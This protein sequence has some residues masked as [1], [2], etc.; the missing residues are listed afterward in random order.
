MKH[1]IALLTVLQTAPMALAAECPTR[2]TL[3]TGIRFTLAS[4]ETETFRT[5]AEG[6]VESLFEGPEQPANRVLLGRGVYLLELIGVDSGIPDPDSRTTYSYPVKPAEMPLPEPG[7][8]WS[9]T[10]AV[11]DMGELRSETQVYE[12]GPA[13]TAGFGACSYEMIPVTIT[14]PGDDSSNT[15]LLHYFPALGL[16]Y[17]A[18]SKYDGNLDRYDYIAIDPVN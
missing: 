11:L 14:Y 1:F 16:S 17:L 13:A 6:L 2:D 8:R 10:A 18:E 7:G 9:V 3:A 12:F 4:G 5:T 15:D